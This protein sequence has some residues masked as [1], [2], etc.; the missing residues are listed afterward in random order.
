M[1]WTRSETLALASHSCASCQG[2]GLR[3]NEPAPNSLP[4]KSEPTPSRSAQPCNCVLRHIFRACYARFRECAMKERFIAKV[5]L[6]TAQCTDFK[7][8]WSRKDEEYIADFCLVSRRSL[9]KGEYLIFNYHYLLGADWRLCCRRLK[10]DRGNFFHSVYKIE[11]RLGRVFR[12]L[13]PYALYPVRDYFSGPIIPVQ[14]FWNIAPK[15]VP[16]RPPVMGVANFD[17]PQE[18]AA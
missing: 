16:I 15:V 17:L 7:R 1:E 10:M 14:S 4:N 2:L 12:E 9:S 8:A 11:Q 3:L 13:K 5:S 18:K 6:E